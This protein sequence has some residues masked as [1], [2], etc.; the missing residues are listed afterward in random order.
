MEAMQSNFAQMQN[1][2]P[3]AVGGGAFGPGK[4][5]N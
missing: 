2:W 4:I 3:T 5:K 1:M